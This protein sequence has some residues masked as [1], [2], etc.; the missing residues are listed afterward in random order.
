MDIFSKHGIRRISV[1]RFRWVVLT[2]SIIFSFMPYAALFLFGGVPDILYFPMP[3][4][5]FLYTSWRTQAG[6]T[7]C[8]LMLAAIFG[9]MLAVPPTRYINFLGGLGR[10]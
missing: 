6:K 10:Y 7:G 5:L 3:W 2:A 4:L 8:I 1:Y 9:I